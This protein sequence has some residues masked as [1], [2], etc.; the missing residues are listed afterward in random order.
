MEGGNQMRVKSKWVSSQTAHVVRDIVGATPAD[1]QRTLHTLHH[2]EVNYK[3][4]WRA[5][6]EVLKLL[7]SRE[8]LSYQ[9]IRPYFSK[10][11]GRM[12]GTITAFERDTNCRLIRTFVMLA[13][14]AESFCWF[15]PMLSFDACHLRGNWKGT[16]MS[17][18]MKDGMGQLQVLAWGT[19]PIE[20][21]AHWSWFAKLVRRGLRR[22]ARRFLARQRLLEEEGLGEEEG[23][24]G[25]VPPEQGE[26][27]EDVGPGGQVP[28]GPLR[29]TGPL[30]PL[31]EDTNEDNSGDISGGDGEDNSEDEYELAEEVSDDDDNGPRQADIPLHL[32]IFSDR[33]KGIA[34]ALKIHFPDCSHVFCMK[35]I[36]RNIVVKFRLTKPVKEAMW[37]ACRAMSCSGWTQYMHQVREE[38]PAICE[39]LLSIPWDQWATAH[40]T[41]P[42]WGETTSNASESANN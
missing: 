21:G 40:A 24:G 7:A 15:K 34:K 22:A 5:R 9:L 37:K 14:L 17:A 29:L 30:R 28:A 36:E 19:A 33:E 10:L 32:T 42:K 20:N 31:H 8:L 38:N 41:C 23:P 39:Y 3:A 13:P 27:D 35:H 16:L 25:Q 12:P 18:T 11:K 1:L 2:V 4:A 6:Q 26:E